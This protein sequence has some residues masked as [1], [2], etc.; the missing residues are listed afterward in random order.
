MSLGA[1]EGLG[2]GQGPLLLPHPLHPSSYTE[3]GPTLGI[4]LQQVRAPRV[5]LGPLPGQGFR[6]WAQSRGLGQ[7]SPR[8]ELLGERG[9]KLPGD[10]RP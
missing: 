10:P 9:K 2:S 7:R 6:L 3:S 5:A 8:A 1:A 4:G